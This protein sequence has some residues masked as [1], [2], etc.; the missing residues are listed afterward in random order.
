MKEKFSQIL[1]EIKCLYLRIHVVFY[2]IRCHCLQICQPSSILSLCWPAAWFEIFDVLWYPCARVVVLYIA[3]IMVMSWSGMG[4]DWLGESLTNA[5]PL[6]IWLLSQIFRP[7]PLPQLAR[8]QVQSCPSLANFSYWPK[9]QGCLHFLA[10]LW[11]WMFCPS[12][13]LSGK[14]SL[15]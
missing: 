8:A 12:G 7:R 1:L 6:L 14:L 13:Y 11:P 9:I 10:C 4:W 2:V 5:H 15:G 3:I